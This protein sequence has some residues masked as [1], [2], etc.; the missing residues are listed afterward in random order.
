MGHNAK[1][2]SSLDVHI[3]TFHKSKGVEK[4]LRYELERFSDSPMEW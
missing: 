1:S 4:G 2:N 3:C